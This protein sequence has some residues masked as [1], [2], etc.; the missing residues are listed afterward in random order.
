[1]SAFDGYWVSF[2]GVN[3]G[4]DSDIYLPLIQSICSSNDKHQALA[5][6]FT[7]K[8]QFQGS[9]IFW[10]KKFCTGRRRSWLIERQ[11]L[12]LGK[13]DSSGCTGSATG[14]MWYRLCVVAQGSQVMQEERCPPPHLSNSRTSG[15]TASSLTLQQDPIHTQLCP[16]LLF[17]CS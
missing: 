13:Q 4:V 7:S 5:P 16:A 12:H 3:L 10:Y 17:L 9:S 8:G 6:A 15:L 1:M 14:V 11:V 2:V